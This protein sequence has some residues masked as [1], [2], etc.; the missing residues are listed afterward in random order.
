M[1]V[2][3]IIANVNVNVVDWDCIKAGAAAYVAVAIVSFLL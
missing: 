3:I 1:Y 2:S